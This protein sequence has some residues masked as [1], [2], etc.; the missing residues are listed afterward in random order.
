MLGPG[1]SPPSYEAATALVDS[2]GGGSGPGGGGRGGGS[3]GGRAR[4]SKVVKKEKITR[5]PSAFLLFTKEKRPE[6]EKGLTFGE[7]QKVLSAAWKV[8]GGGK[9]EE[10]GR[11]GG[12]KEE[13]SDGEQKKCGSVDAG[14]SIFIG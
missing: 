7:Q 14:C 10:G 11:E 3:E 2:K 5:S 8:R 9:R 1:G 6:M 12:S 13:R 4:G